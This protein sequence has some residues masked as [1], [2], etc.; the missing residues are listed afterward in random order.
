M[1][2][3]AKLSIILTSVVLISCAPKVQERKFTVPKAELGPRL[4]DVDL[5]LDEKSKSQKVIDWSSLTYTSDYFKVIEDLYKIGSLRQ[6]QNFKDIGLQLADKYYSKSSQVEFSNSPYIEAATYNAKIEIASTLE[7]VLNELRKGKSDLTTVLNNTYNKLDWPTG[8]ITTT[9]F[10]GKMKQFFDL[11]NVEIKS[12]NLYPPLAQTLDKEIPAEVNPLLTSGEEIARKID[13]TSS[14]I[15]LNSLIQQAI[16]EFQLELDP[17]KK[18]QIDN[19]NKISNLLQ[20]K[21]AQGA[22]TLIVEIWNTLT[23]EERIENFK[24]TSVE[25]YKYL[26]KQSD[27]DLRC[28]AKTNCARIIKVF[29]KKVFVLP[30]LRKYGLEKLRRT[31]NESA[32]I[33]AKNQIKIVLPQTYPEILKFTDSKIQDRIDLKIDEILQIQENPEGFIQDLVDTWSITNLFA[34]QGKI[35]SLEGQSLKVNV[36]DD[37]TIKLLLMDQNKSTP[38]TLGNS[39]SS[40]SFIL[41]SGQNYKYQNQLILSQINKLLALSGFKD[42]SGLHIPGSFFSTDKSLP[43]FDIEKLTSYTQPFYIQNLFN[44]DTKFRIYQNTDTASMSVENQAQLLNGLS[45]F[46]YYFS[47]WNKTAF[48]QQLGNVRIKDILP[49]LDNDAANKSLFPKESLVALALGNAAVLLKNLTKELSPLFLM[50]VSNK[51]LWSDEYLKTDN[52]DTTVTAGIVDIVNSQR[53]SVVYAKSVSEYLIALTEFYK[54]ITGI[55]NTNSAYIKNSIDDL[56]DG[57]QKIKLLIIA[58]SNYISHDLMNL[59]FQIKT[60]SLSSEVKV[61]DQFAAI[62]ALVSSY[63]ITGIDVYLWSAMEIYYSMNNRNF[64]KTLGFYLNNNSTSEI[65][66]INALSISEG[67]AALNKLY[68]YL[69]SASQAQL[70]RVMLPWFSSLEKVK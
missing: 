11:L 29:E 51:I 70:N 58:L 42:H 34:S 64:N 61:S 10:V 28:L 8:E 47:D 40:S 60:S 21:D 48:D 53:Q 18:E 1:K 52:F 15:E 2:L 62:E 59:N 55:Q 12:A 45:K 5:G 16:S 4:S 43:E 38:A 20:F 41:Q 39:L 33:Y 6:N 23:Q 31:I 36:S 63:E 19:G 24:T 30:K 46:I 66:K 67:L 54:S 37:N 27:S 3:K 35:Y 49:E 32:L 65:N 14:F 69:P 50:S 57:K 22:L 56:L 25:L 9:E 13:S 44:I 68:A 7:E 17:D 26:K